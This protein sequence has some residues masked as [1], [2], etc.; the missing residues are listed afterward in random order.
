M[1]THQKADLLDEFAAKVESLHIKAL[2]SGSMERGVEVEFEIAEEARKLAAKV[3]PVK[4]KLRV[5][6]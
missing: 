1:N 5:A 6:R 2:T 3:R 4:D